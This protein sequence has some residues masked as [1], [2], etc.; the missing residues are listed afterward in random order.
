MSLRSFQ[1][2]AIRG[3]VAVE[4]IL[5]QSFQDFEF[6]IIDGGS[7]DGSLDVIKQ[8]TDRITFWVSEPDKGIYNGMNK[9]IAQAT[10]TYV[11][12]MNSGDSFYDNEVLEK[13]SNKMDCSDFIIGKDYN[14]NTRTGKS[15]TTILPTRIS[16]ALNGKATICSWPAK[17]CSGLS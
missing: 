7:N 6:I 5:N 8:Y 4:S 1:R 11:N 3:I 2:E 12:F 10:G 15:F 13:V 16:M 9:G 17:P 14:L